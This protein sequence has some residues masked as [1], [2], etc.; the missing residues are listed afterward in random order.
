MGGAGVE[1]VAKALLVAAG[2]EAGASGA[3][4]RAGDV[5]ACETHSVCRDAVDVRSRDLLGET[6]AVEFS[7]AEIVPNDN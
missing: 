6:L 1:F 4:I 5:A 7:V 3:A 2:E